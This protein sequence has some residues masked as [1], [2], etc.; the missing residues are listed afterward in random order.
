MTTAAGAFFFRYRNILGPVIFL[1]ALVFARP[2]QPFG[3]HALGAL[4]AAAGIM[5][6]LAGQGLRVLTIGY[7][8]IERGGRNRTVY[9][10]KL[11]TGGMFAHCR[12]PL[13]VGNILIACGFAL[14]INAWTFY[15]LVLPFVLLSYIAIVA[16]EENFLRNEFGSAYAEY[17]AR[18]KRW[19]PR[20][21]GWSDTV[22]A[23]RFNWR[24]VLVKE[25]NTLFVTPLA[26]AMILAWR[27]LRLHGTASLP[28]APAA[29]LALLAWLLG[30]LAV[31]WLK[32]SG[33]VRE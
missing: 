28:G 17:C 5:L 9:A 16:T 26:L 23:M 20:W 7:Q 19:W 27:E 24:R 30:Y 3:D 18:V 8:Y 33:R 25:Y 13:Y 6:V 2:F 15:L 21:Q 32:K 12:N 22:A 31:R 11:V 1:I 10:S 29:G 4:F 14:V